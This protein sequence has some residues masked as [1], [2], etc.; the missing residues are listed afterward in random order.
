MKITTQAFRASKIIVKQ[1]IKHTTNGGFSVTEI[2]I[3]NDQGDEIFELS[4]FSK[5]VDGVPVLVHSGSPAT[6]EA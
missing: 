5:I 1:P 3:V 4:V 2:V 6:V